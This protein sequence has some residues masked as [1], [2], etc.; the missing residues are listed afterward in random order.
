MAASYAMGARYPRA[1]C[2]RMGCTSFYKSK[3]IHLRFG[4]ERRTDAFQPSHSRVRRSSRNMARFVASSPEPWQAARPLPGSLA[5]AAQGKRDPHRYVAG[6]LSTEFPRRRHLGIIG[7]CE[8]RSS[9]ERGQ[10]AKVMD[11]LINSDNLCPVGHRATSPAQR[12]RPQLFSVLAE[13]VRRWHISHSSSAPPTPPLSGLALPVSRLHPR[14]RARAEPRPR[15]RRRSNRTAPLA[16]GNPG[17]KPGGKLRDNCL[18][19]GNQSPAASAAGGNGFEPSSPSE[20]FYQTSPPIG[21]PG[22]DRR[23]MA[24]AGCTVPLPS[25]SVPFARLALGSEGASPS[26]RRSAFRKL[27]EARRRGGRY[28]ARS[29]S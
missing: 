20:E 5:D 18:L 27:T 26:S 28:H 2:S 6:D 25:L 22:A 11:L 19:I 13:N 1:E 14:S 12:V 23:E 4:P 15:E 3:T 21:A 29:S 8:A 7:K 10:V 24:N 9:P 17:L 16:E